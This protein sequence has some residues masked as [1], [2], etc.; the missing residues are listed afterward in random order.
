MTIFP[1]KDVKGMQSF[2]NHVQGNSSS[3]QRDNLDELLHSYVKLHP[4][5]TYYELHILLSK[6]SKL[7]LN[8]KYLTLIWREYNIPIVLILVLKQYFV[9]N[10][11]QPN[12]RSHGGCDF[13]LKLF[14]I[15]RIL[16]IRNNMF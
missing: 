13:D 8:H 2:S 4:N 6:T 10:F 14:L 9:L 16:K 15:I 1:G 12:S 7:S 5:Y 11:Q 3:Q